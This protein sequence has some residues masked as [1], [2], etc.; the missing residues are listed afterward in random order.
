MRPLCCKGA[1]GERRSRRSRARGKNIA[2]PGSFSASTAE[3]GSFSDEVA[4]T[5]NAAR[6]HC[7]LASRGLP[8]PRAAQTDN[9]MASGP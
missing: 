6:T 3:T 7:A 2:E 9:G 4:Q 5:G 8:A 1:R